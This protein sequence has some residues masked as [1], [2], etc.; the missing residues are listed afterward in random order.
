MK[1][2]IKIPRKF[3]VILLASVVAICV[4]S[5]TIGRE[6]YAEKT[7]SIFSFGLVHFSGYLFFLLMPVELAFI[8]YLPFYSGL[9][10]IA[11]ALATTM[12]VQCIDYGFGRLIRPKRIFKLMD[13]EKI[14]KA[15]HKIRQYGMLTIFVFN[16]LP[17]SSPVIALAAGMLH[18]RFKR[19]FAVSAFGL[20][21]KY[22]VLFWCFS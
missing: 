7:E 14:V 8:Y 10:V 5:F 9:E 3:Y 17:L 19:F 22:L 4:F 16:L 2:R 1:A 15:E 6:L 11:V 21:L 18:Y 13:R 12:V 20:L